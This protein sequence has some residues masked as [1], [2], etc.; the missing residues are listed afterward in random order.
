M[1]RYSEAEKLFPNTGILAFV[2]KWGNSASEG[3]D[4]RTKQV[5]APVS[6]SG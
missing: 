2:C 1:C 5:N 6:V 3:Q 4:Q